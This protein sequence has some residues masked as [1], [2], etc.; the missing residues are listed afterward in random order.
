MTL[1]NSRLYRSTDYFKAS[2]EVVQFDL[3]NVRDARG[4]MNFAIVS[5]FGVAAV[6][7]DGGEMVLYVTGVLHPAPLDLTP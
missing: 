5:K 1:Q 6:R 7:R 3:P 4:V 2:K